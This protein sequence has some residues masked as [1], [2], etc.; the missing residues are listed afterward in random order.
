M[1]DEIAKVISAQVQYDSALNGMTCNATEYKGQHFSKE[2]SQ[3]FMTLEYLQTYG[4]ITVV[5][6]AIAFNCPYKSSLSSYISVL[7]KQGY[8][9]VAYKNKTN[10]SDTIYLLK[11]DEQKKLDRS[12]QKYSL[13]NSPRLHGVWSKMKERCYRKKNKSYDY[14]GGRGISVC[15]EWLY[16]FQAFAEWAMENGYDENADF[17]KCT[18]DRIDNNGNYEPSNC[19]F[20]T[21]KKQCN[22]RRNN[23]FLTLGDE[24]HTLSEWGDI[25]GISPDTL[26]RRIKSGWTVEKAIK[27]PVR[28]Q[29][30]NRIKPHELEGSTT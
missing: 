19:R 28:I 6:S 24:T 23:R 9:I 25:V 2:K 16:S 10:R 13:S 27:T 18:L 8:Y 22:N 15:D 1:S 11:T 26:K 4:S 21:I 29:K 14:Y 3:T 7:R 17:M 30:N 20:I 12:K 5:E